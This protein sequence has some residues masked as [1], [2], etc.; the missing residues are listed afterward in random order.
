MSFSSKLIRRFDEAFPR[1]AFGSFDEW[2]KMFTKEMDDIQSELKKNLTKTFTKGSIHYYNIDTDDNDV[3]LNDLQEVKNKMGDDIT[4]FFNGKKLIEDNVGSK[5]IEIEVAD[6][7]DTDVCEAPDID[8]REAETTCA[9]TDLFEKVEKACRDVKNKK[10]KNM[11]LK[12]KT[13]NE[14]DNSH[15]DSMKENMIVDGEPMTMENIKIKIPEWRLFNPNEVAGVS[16]YNSDMIRIRLT[17]FDFRFLD[18]ITFLHKYK[19]IEVGDIQ[20]S[21]SKAE[22]VYN[23]MYLVNTENY[24]TL[25]NGSRNNLYE[26]ILYFKTGDLLNKEE[27]ERNNS[28]IPNP[29]NCCNGTCNCVV[30]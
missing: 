3:I 13:L 15:N 10:I 30:I 9:S 23:N 21:N 20:I 7:P 19:W 2:E 28:K 24:E 16:L 14:E 1:N 26:I 17:P 27:K 12:N 25:Y 5:T 6:N 8:V 18:V 11:E 22:Y 29:D 4:I